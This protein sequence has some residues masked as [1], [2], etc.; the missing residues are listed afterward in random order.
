MLDSFV[1]FFNLWMEMPIQIFIR[2]SCELNLTV[3]KSKYK[4]TIL[5]FVFNFPISFKVLSYFAADIW[6]W[7]FHTAHCTMYITVYV[8]S[9]CM[10]WRFII[11]NNWIVFNCKILQKWHTSFTK[12]KVL[13]EGER[14]LRLRENIC[15][16]FIVNFS[17]DLWK[18]FNLGAI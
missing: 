16:I 8:W 18:E 14:K 15:N 9:L 1:V 4:F 5:P 10:I 17:C 2:F 13:I 3:L 11:R 12:R 7:G 6:V